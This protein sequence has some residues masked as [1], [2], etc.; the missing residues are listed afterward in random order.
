MR[1]VSPTRSALLQL[2]LVA[3]VVG[4]AVAPAVS[5]ATTL[6]VDSSSERLSRS[7]GIGTDSA[8]DAATRSANLTVQTLVAPGAHYDRLTS[9][10]ALRAAR[11]DATLTPAS[12]G[13]DLTYEDDVIAYRD[14]AVHRVELTGSA[15]A[16]ADRLEAANGTGPTERFRS[17]LA[18]GSVEFTYYG[19]SACPPELAVNASFDA[20]A[21]RVVTDPENDTVTFVLDLD[22]LRFHPLGG[23]E[24]TTDTRVL[25]HHSFGLGLSAGGLVETA[26]G[27]ETGYHVERGAA[28]LVGRYDG[29]VRLDP[30]AD[31]TLR[32]R[33]MLAPGSTVTVRLVP[34]ARAD[35]VEIT[36]A[37][38]NRS[39]R[40][41]VT[42]DLRPVPD[43]TIYVVG[44]ESMTEPP[45]VDAGGTFVAVGDATGAIVD[46]RAQNSTGDILYGP[47][48]TT[49]HGG[50]VTVRNASGGLIGVSEYRKPGASVAQIDLAPALSTDQRVTVTVYRDAN[51]NRAFDEAD[52]PYRVSGS[53][54]RDTAM[55]TLEGQRMTTTEPPVITDSTSTATELTP[56]S[57]A[58]S[59]G[60]PGF[61]VLAALVGG[62]VALGLRA[63]V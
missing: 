42:L 43:G 33:T 24:P 32:G 55:V 40:F 26:A 29:L 2:V 23:G 48:L 62:L 37:T 14:I 21:I 13:V 47:A 12:V 6:P 57:P 27:A 41:A 38:V 45:V 50:F 10:A 39:R 34:Y 56:A 25:G 46:L 22:R 30:A 52:V 51:G 9:P 58:S 44:Y 35:S 19:P 18:N 36:R 54:V 8:V 20:G 4:L 31:Q 1:A 5:A 15:T 28:E 7:C 17:L 59:P 60:Q 11:A 49:T 53:L 63:R 61:G 16:L 3:S